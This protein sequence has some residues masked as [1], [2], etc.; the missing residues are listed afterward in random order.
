MKI[1]S[2]SFSIIQNRAAALIFRFAALFACGAGLVALTAAG[3]RINW[4]NL[5]YFTNL[6][7]LACLI[8]YLHLIIKTI[9]D[10]NKQGVCGVSSAPPFF[11]GSVM[12]MLTVTMLVYHFMLSGT[13][14]VMT[15]NSDPKILTA[16]YLLHYAAPILTLLDWLLFDIKK[17][18]KRA[19]PLLW[20]T[21]PFCYT[22]FVFIRAETGGLIGGTGSRYPYYFLDADALGMSG[23]TAYAGL[24][25]LA[26]LVLGYVFYILD[27]FLT[28]LGEKK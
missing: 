5:I 7:N 9:I 22:V 10:I 15:V 24:L 26:F 3:G 28:R 11:R 18:F 25:A 27:N 23:V 6:S 14:F 1:N 19:Y 16:N 4:M 21:I 13:G 20:L 12:M 17:V 8:F 2:F